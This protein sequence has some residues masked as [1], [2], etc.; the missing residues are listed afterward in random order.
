MVK[1]AL[2]GCILAGLALGG[3]SDYARPSEQGVDGAPVITQA[4]RSQPRYAEDPVAVRALDPVFDMYPDS[5]LVD[6]SFLLDAPAGKH[7]FVEAGE[8]GRFHFSHSGERV[9]FWG[10]TVA[11]NHVD[12]EK[13]RIETVVD[14]A[15]R[16]GCNLLR[17]HEIDNRGGEKYNLVRRNILDEAYPHQNVS[18]VFNPE[19]RDRV[20][21]WIHRCQERGVYVYLVARG[22]RTFRPGD[23]VP[24]AEKM[25]RSAKPYAMFDPRLI[26]LQKEYLDAW[27]FEHVNPY[28]GVPNGLNPAVCCIEIENEDSLFFNHVP[29]RDFIEPYRSDF[30]RRWNEWL[31]ERYGSLEG[32]QQ[33]WMDEAGRCALQEGEDPAQGTVEL[34]RMPRKSLES[35]DSKPWEDSLVAPVRM[36]DGAIFAAALQRGYFATLRDHLRAKGCRVPL[37][38]VVDSGVLL[39]TWTV[40]KELDSTGENA[41]LDHPSFMPGKVWVGKPLY[42]NKNYVKE[43]GPWSL[44]PHMARYRW[45]GTPLIC[46]EWATCWPNA[47]RASAALDIASFSLVQDYDALIHFSYYTW[48]NPETINAFGPQADPPR[49]GLFGYAALLF[50]RG[51]LQPAPRSIALAYN[52]ED[53]AT[54]AS[55]VRPFQELAWTNR[56]ENW[57]PDDEVSRGA[58]KPKNLLLTIVS[59]RSGRGSYLGRDLVLFDARYSARA[60]QPPEEQEKGLLAQSGYDRPWIYRQGGFP[61]DAVKAAGY[62]PVLEEAQAEA[63]KAFYDANRNALVLG[64]VT[65]RQATQLSA[66]FAER[67]RA[68]AA[69]FA[70]LTAE[71]RTELVA[72]DGR[73]ARDAESGLLRIATERF[74]A[75]AGELE[76]GKPLKAGV[77]SV[78]SVSP[79]GTVVAA[80][81]DGL[82]LAQSR[83]YAIKMATVAQ[84]RGQQLNPVDD[85]AAPQ[86]YVLDHPGAAPVQTL[87]QSSEK[88]TRVFVGDRPVVEAYLVNGTWEIVIDL[89]KEECLVACDTRNVRFRLSPALFG[90]SETKEVSIERYFY[91]F[92][93]RDAGQSGWDFIYPGFAKYVRL[94][95]Q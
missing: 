42:S 41:Y 60:K 58:A 92:P 16:A 7:G 76:P 54:W 10:V 29:W 45:S 6:F 64:D 77:L 24:G 17:L 67:L 70:D 62:V 36:R 80:S 38:A 51:D 59:G 31:L 66:A 56:I 18:S 39:D 69:D 15:A 43:T 88:P 48:G 22:Y 57:N 32:L 20:D 33:E 11:A 85:P 40:A 55:W 26:E 94:S 14:V 91:E 50:L 2:F 13:S 61:T 47:Y 95:S 65:E 63:C 71:P 78:E 34:P 1:Q 89:D 93:P 79:I 75:L 9:R 86:K 25:I 37:T 53:L 19:Y 87:G 46:R 30:Q 90:G 44:G 82:P 83:R 12:I 8:D 73:L 23:G 68:G 4:R 21:Y 35:L 5:S 27:L 84:N 72:L 52:T 49:W 81:L 28:T 74:C 3:W